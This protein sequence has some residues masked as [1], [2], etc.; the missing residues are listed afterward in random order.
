MSAANFISPLG[1]ARCDA[2]KLTGPGEFRA[3]CAFAREMQNRKS[4]AFGLQPTVG[5]NVVTSLAKASA[6]ANTRGFSALSRRPCG[7]RGRE[8]ALDE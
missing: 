7:I 4:L 3:G 8:S 1:G 6:E 2:K 5:A